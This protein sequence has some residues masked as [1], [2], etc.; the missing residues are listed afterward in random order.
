M[1][2]ARNWVL[3]KLILIFCFFQ[4]PFTNVRRTFTLAINEKVNAGVRRLAQNGGPG[5]CLVR[6]KLRSVLGFLVLLGQAKRTKPLRGYE[7]NNNYTIV[8]SQCDLNT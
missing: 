2:L 4:S 5:V 1:C 3:E 6:W 7:R 8:L